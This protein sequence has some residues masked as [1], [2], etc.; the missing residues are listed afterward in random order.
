MRSWIDSFRLLTAL[1]NNPIGNNAHRKA[2][3]NDRQSG[4]PEFW[5]V[6]TRRPSTFLPKVRPVFA[7]P[8]VR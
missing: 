6:T 8:I 1:Q 5:V 4:S 2:R 3:T 7:H